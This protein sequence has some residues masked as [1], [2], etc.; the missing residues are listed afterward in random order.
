MNTDEIDRVLLGNKLTKTVFKG[1]FP[2]DLAIYERFK[3]PFAVILN[4]STSDKSTG[5][6][7]AVYKKLNGPPLYF[8]SYGRN[9]NGNTY[10]KTF[11]K[12]L[13]EASQYSYYLYNPHSLQAD[14]SNVCGLYCIIFIYFIRLGYSFTEFLQTIKLSSRLQ[15]DCFI[16]ELFSVLFSPQVNIRPTTHFTKVCQWAANKNKGKCNKLGGGGQKGKKRWGKP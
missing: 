1:T 11:V 12:K 14:A 5:H 7:V 6:W 8:D 16:S 15:N 9:A 10:V 3:V 13:C 2:C 4:T